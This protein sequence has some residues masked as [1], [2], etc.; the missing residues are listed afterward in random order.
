M[1]TAKVSAKKEKLNNYEMVVILSP[2]LIDDQLETAINNITNF[3]T[4]RGGTISQLDRWGKRALAYPIKHSNSG[5]YVVARFTLKPGACKE[6]ETSLKISE[7]VLRHLLIK[8]ETELTP[9]KPAV[10]TPA[11]AAP[12]APPAAPAAPVIA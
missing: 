8:P 12:D 1:V 4:N 3:I 7:N 11:S 6:L 10:A 5:T 9:V 2:Q